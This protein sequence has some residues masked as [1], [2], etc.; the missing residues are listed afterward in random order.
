VII[1]IPNVR[2]F[3]ELSPASGSELYK[4][5]LKQPSA[6]GT[7]LVAS[8]VVTTLILAARFKVTAAL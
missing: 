7:G 2:T 6:I 1:I 3:V 5:K 4:S 8:C